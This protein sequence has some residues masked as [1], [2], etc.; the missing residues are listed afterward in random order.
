MHTKKS[1]DKQRFHAAWTVPLLLSKNS[2][3]NCP[4]VFSIIQKNQNFHQKSFFEFQ[5]IILSAL[6]FAQPFEG[7]FETSGWL[8][9]EGQRQDSYFMG[10]HVLWATEFNFRRNPESILNSLNNLKKNHNDSESFLLGKL[11][12]KKRNFKEFSVTCMIKQIR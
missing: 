5:T 12:Y 2:S 8:E 7:T 1:A 4:C 10:Y 11:H 3:Q 6:H 9:L